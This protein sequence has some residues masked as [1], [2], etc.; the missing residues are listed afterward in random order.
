MEEK[1][2]DSVS[3][4]V[5]E[6]INADNMTIIIIF[7]AII[8]VPKILSKM[9]EARERKQ[10]EKIADKAM[11]GWVKTGKK[12]KT[13]MDMLLQQYIVWTFIFS[14]CLIVHAMVYYFINNSWAHIIS[15]TVHILCSCVYGRFLWKSEKIRENI[16]IKKM[17]KIIASVF[18]YIVFSITLYSTTIA[19]STDLPISVFWIMLVAWAI[20]IFI[21]WESKYIYENKYVTVNT[22]EFG[23][24]EN[25]QAWNIKNYK[26]W[27]SLSVCKKGEIQE[28]R[29]KK[30]DIIGAT[31]Y[32]K[33]VSVTSNVRFFTTYNTLV[34]DQK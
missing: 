12:E 13:Y 34:E 21:E 2:F 8:S 7:V 9:M 26:G 19:S 10:H 6:G 30:E 18:V 32:G 33:P 27:I 14:G 16:K 20:Y 5:E 29:I 31:Y 3:K 24:I 22:K 17:H 11:L 23:T 4:M 1:L 15:K 28:K 25:V